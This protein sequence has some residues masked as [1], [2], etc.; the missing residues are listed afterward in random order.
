[1]FKIFIDGQEG[2]TG[3]QIHERLK[4]REDLRLLE[5]PSQARKDAEARAGLL[6]EA[7][8]VVLCLPDEAARESVQLLKNDRT[9]VIDASTAFRTA[10]GWV[11]GLPELNPDQRN[12]IRRAQRVANPGCHATGF[13]A[14]LYPLVQAEIVPPDYPVVCHSVTGYSGGGK[15][16]IGIYESVLPMAEALR[17]P[18]HYALNLRH[19]HL[20]EM[21]KVT[22]LTNPPLFTPIVAPFYKG[23]V[24]SIPLFTA[25]LAKKMTAR[26][27]SDFLSA[28]YGNEPFIRVM[29]FDS[30]PFLD[31]G[32]LTPSECND[33]NRVDLF[34]FGNDEQVLLASR[35]D[36]LGKGA[37]GAAVQNLN[38]ML[39]VEETTG[40]A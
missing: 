21:Q 9:K 14:A 4:S 35:L 28:Y 10:P 15:K 6:N 29:P 1:M 31:N 22:G 5:I 11:Y 37:S 34:V 27:I 18:R 3:L 17:G 32:F 13:I 30:A 40:L 23:M 2:T 20:P 25:L 12:L 38:I 16:L 19:K 39:G 26:G 8:L 7:D 24:V 36:N 33:S